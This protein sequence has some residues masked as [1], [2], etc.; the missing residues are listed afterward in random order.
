MVSIQ[1]SPISGVD[2]ALRNAAARSLC[3]LAALMAK[4]APTA[5]VLHSLQAPCFIAGNCMMPSGKSGG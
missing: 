1:R 4:L 5:S 3:R 2:M